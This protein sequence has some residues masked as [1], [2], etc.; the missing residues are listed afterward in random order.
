MVVL[1]RTYGA[2]ILSII[3]YKYDV[4]NGINYKTTKLHKNKNPKCD[5]DKIWL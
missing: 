4:P 5:C 3:F 1:L 2:G